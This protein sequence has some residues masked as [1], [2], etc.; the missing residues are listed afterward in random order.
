VILNE[1]IF[2]ESISIEEL[3]KLIEEAAK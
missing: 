3:T 2:D 1:H